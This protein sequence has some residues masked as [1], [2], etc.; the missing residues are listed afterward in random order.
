MNPA[1]SPNPTLVCLLR[2]FISAIVSHVMPVIPTWNPGPLVLCLRENLVLLSSEMDS[3][4]DLTGASASASATPSGANSVANGSS[5][6]LDV[7][8]ANAAAAE[9]AGQKLSSLSVA[10]S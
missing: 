9:A 6:A 1:S 3:D 7:Q 2:L 5:A 4:E 8:A 10:S